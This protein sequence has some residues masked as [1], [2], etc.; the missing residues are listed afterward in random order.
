VGFAGL[1][2]RLHP[3]A[4]L[5]ARWALEQPASYVAFDVVT[6]GDTPT[7]SEA[8]QRR[9]E[10]L[11]ALLADA[12]PPLGLMPMTTNLDAAETWMAHYHAPGV[13]GVVFK[14]LAQPYRPGLAGW[15]KLRIR[16]SAEAVIVGV[17]GPRSSPE[18]LIIGRTDTAGRLRIAGRALPLPAAARV[19]LAALLTDADPDHPWPPTVPGSRLGQLASGKRIPYTQVQP[20]LV[21]ELEVDTAYEQH[22][23]RHPAQFIRVR[24][25]LRPTDLGPHVELAE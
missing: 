15:S 20:R 25:D 10:R 1:Q 22:R 14:R 19:E 13:E 9:R 12:T 8:Y 18:S 11:A 7:H 2:R 5:A 21:V 6:I 17:I 3:S 16:H 23:W 4:S 24:A